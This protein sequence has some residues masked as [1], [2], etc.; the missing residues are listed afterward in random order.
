MRPR[1]RIMDRSLGTDLSNSNIPQNEE[2]VNND[3][4]NILNNLRI[5]MKRRK[6]NM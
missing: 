5:I 2:D 6:Q 3:N 1:S 4:K